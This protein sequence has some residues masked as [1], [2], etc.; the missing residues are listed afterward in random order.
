MDSRFVAKYRQF[1]ASLTS[2]VE[3]MRGA[4]AAMMSGASPRAMVNDLMAPAR[5]M[6][7]FFANHD[8]KSAAMRQLNENFLRGINGE[9]SLQQA[10]GKIAGAQAETDKDLPPG[11]YARFVD[12]ANAYFRERAKA[13]PTTIRGRCSARYRA[14]S[15]PGAGVSDRHVPRGGLLLRQR[16]RGPLSPD[17][18]A[19][20]ILLRPG[21]AAASSRRREG[22]C[23]NKIREDL[24][25]SMR[26][27]RTSVGAQIKRL[28]CNPS[29]QI[30]KGVGS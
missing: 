11:R 3:G 5:D 1:Y 9:P 29:Q 10:D 6:Q 15:A 8:A 17:H 7:R 20:G 21:L 14:V 27:D 4:A 26:A 13:H 25:V 30:V 12:G 16:F 24:K 22:H 28:S 2:R 18:G 23:G 19:Q